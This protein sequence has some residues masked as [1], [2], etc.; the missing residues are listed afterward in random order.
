MKYLDAVCPTCKGKGKVATVGKYYRVFRKYG[1][2]VPQDPKEFSDVAVARQ[3]MH[4]H[5]DS[6]YKFM[7]VA[8]DG[9]IL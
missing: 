5:K 3:Y 7:L 9:T 1:A 4:D 2:T 8:P 6:T